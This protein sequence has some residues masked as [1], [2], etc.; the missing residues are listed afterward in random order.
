MVV[1]NWGAPL[2]R[3]TILIGCSI[4]I[5]AA[6]PPVRIAVDGASSGKVFDGIGAT[7]AGGPSRM[8]IDYPSAERSKILDLLFKPNYGASLQ[9]LKVEIGGDSNVGPGSESSH[10]RTATDENYNRGYEWWLMEEARR[11]NPK[12]KLLALAWN[13][14]GWVKK[15]NSQATAD[16][17]VKFL[18]GAKRMHGLDIDYIGIWNETPMDPAFIPLLRATLDRAGL[19]TKIIADDLV[20]TWSI[21]DS[22]EKSVAVR[23]SIDVISTHYPH[24][25]ST[26][27]AKKRS[28]EWGKPLWSSEEGPWDDHWAATGQEGFSYAA[29][30]NRNYVQ[31]RMTSSNIWA[32]I[33]AYYDSLAL[34][35]SGLMRADSPW[36]GGYRVM[37]PIWVVA[38]TT[39]FAQPGWRYLDSASALLPGGGSYV[40]LRSGKDFSTIVETMGAKSSQDATFELSN[41]ISTGP[42]SVWRSNAKSWFQRVGT[43]RPVGGRFSYRFD[44][45]SVYSLTTTTGQHKGIAKS[46]PERPFPMPYR[47]DFENYAIGDTNP[48]YFAELNGSFEIRPCG[49]GRAGKCLAQMVETTP[50]PWTYWGLSTETGIPAVLGDSQWRDYR[51]KADVLIEKPGYA[52][53]IGRMEHADSDGQLF[54]YQFRLYDTGR[55][56]LHGDVKNALIKA[57]TVMP[58]L[59][60]WRSLALSFR[61]DHIIGSIDGREVFDQRDSKHDHGLAGIG[62]GWMPARFDNLVI[63]PVDRGVPVKYKIA[64]NTQSLPPRT[65]PVLVMPEV[66]SNTVILRWQ[67]VEGATSYRVRVASRENGTPESV[68]DAGALP[69]YTVRTLTNGKRYYFTVTAVNRAGESKPS[70]EQVGIPA[71]SP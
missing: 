39:Q 63:E 10:M 46:P 13:F 69:T 64:S 9:M 35:Y 27:K 59:N 54:G 7:S 60:R 20:N 40:T 68:I 61:G 12:I 5:S 16:Y 70:N 2:R 28:A 57:G 37:S 67:A 43:I 31:G 34:P 14:P 4:L 55:W 25:L 41:G 26:E 58:G 29:S 8:L 22:M 11:R 30:L 18:T 47:D 33:T 50:V 1:R 56:E 32:L 44:P 71:A 24:F 6:S 21:V 45:S 17:L 53:L 38:H 42:I 65:A 52:M 49:A 36:S 48:R 19:K 51:V 62:S 66:S 3:A 15:G 23:D